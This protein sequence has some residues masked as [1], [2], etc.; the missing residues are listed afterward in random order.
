MFKTPVELN[1]MY[2]LDGHELKSYDKTALK[3]YYAKVGKLEFNIFVEELEEN[4]CDIKRGDYIGLQV[5]NDHME[6][7]TVTDDGRVNYDNKH[8]YYGTR[9]YYRTVKCAAVGDVKET[10]GL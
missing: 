3:G 1:V 6:F 7:F 5:T 4:G 2:N 9:P 8:T 10:V